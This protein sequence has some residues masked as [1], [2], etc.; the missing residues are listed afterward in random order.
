[1]DAAMYEGA[2][3][4]HA[5]MSHAW[6]PDTEARGCSMDAPVAP[7]AVIIPLAHI[8]A[9]AVDR[10]V[11]NVDAKVA[12]EALAQAVAV[13]VRLPVEAAIGV[14]VA[15]VV[16]GRVAIAVVEGVA[17]LRTRS[18]DR[19]VVD[20]DAVRARVAVTGLI[21]VLHRIRAGAIG[22]GV[23]DTLRHR[24]AH[25]RAG[26]VDCVVLNVDACK[27]RDLKRHGAEHGLHAPIGIR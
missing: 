15:R 20:V 13:S 5:L 7:S 26:A 25:I 11:L 22:V 8:R 9:G 12:V 4:R 3:A 10:V 27:T 2:R 6:R 16:S 18:V 14:A 23:A 21:A 1:M 17:L 19:I 24:R